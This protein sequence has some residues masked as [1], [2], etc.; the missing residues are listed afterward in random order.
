MSAEWARTNLRAGGVRHFELLVLATAVAAA[1]AARKGAWRTGDSLVLLVLAAA[2]AVFSRG[3]APFAIVAAPALAGAAT[4][5]SSS[6]PIPQFLRQPG[7]GRAGAVTLA[8]ILA[9]LLV[10]ERPRAGNESWTVYSLR[11]APM[12]RGATTLLAQGQFPG[13]FYNDMEWGSY[14][15]A[16]LWPGRQVFVDTRPDLYERAGVA[17]DARLIQSARPGWDRA[18]DRW[19]VQSILTHK[20]GRLEKEL[21][22][23]RQWRCAYYGKAVAVYVR[24]ARQ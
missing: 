3:M 18:L 15:T 17:A 14:L 23:S 9:L 21:R 24:A 6:Q 5:W 22:Q 1:L 4:A 10:H 8:V 11:M 2:G 7:L 16:Q 19:G 12:P 13:K 20:R